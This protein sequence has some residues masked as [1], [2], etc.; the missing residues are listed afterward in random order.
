LQHAEL[1]PTDKVLPEDG[2]GIQFPKRRVF[3]I[4]DT[5]LDNVQD[6]D[7]FDRFIYV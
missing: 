2:E 3:K 7:G 1:G 5:T 6:C 4:K